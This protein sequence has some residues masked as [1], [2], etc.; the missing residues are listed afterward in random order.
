[1]HSSCSRC[2][3][4]PQQQQQAA[5]APRRDA[6]QQPE[7]AAPQAHASASDAELK[8]DGLLMLAAAMAPLLMDVGPASA[9]NPLLT[10]KTVSTFAEKQS[11]PDQELRVP[12]PL[13]LSGGVGQRHTMRRLQHCECRAACLARSSDVARTSKWDAP[14]NR[15]SAPDTNKASVVHL[16]Q[17]CRAGVAG[18]PDHHV[19]AAGR[20]PLHRHPGL[21][22]PHRTPHPGALVAALAEAIALPNDAPEDKGTFYEWFPVPSHF[23]CTS[24]G[25]CIACQLLRRAATSWGSSPSAKKSVCAAV[26]RCA[27]RC[28]TGGLCAALHRCG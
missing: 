2:T 25:T 17:M 5:T 24:R 21:E 26:P 11:W 8:A 9:D 3:V 28:R 6:Q 7:P 19:R 10:G 12:P 18:A 16:T 1:M 22:L 14:R 15:S 13:K 4:R 20:V 23:S 27:L